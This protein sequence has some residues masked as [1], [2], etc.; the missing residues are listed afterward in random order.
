MENDFNIITEQIGFPCVIK[1]RS[2]GSSI[3]VSIAGTKEELTKALKYATKYE[4]NVLI[5]KLV[6]GREFSVGI[7]KG[8]ALP[9]IEIIP[10]KGFYDYKNK[11]QGGLTK[12]I[13]PAKLSRELTQ[14]VQKRALLVHK[15]LRLGDY[16]RIDF[17]L[18][19]A[20]E[21]ICLEAN[22]ASGNDSHQFN[23]SGSKAKRYHLSKT[24]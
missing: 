7:L 14:K 6:K 17:I 9:V 8:E 3:G 20:D 5:E 16:S 10:L 19:E 12:E 22:T 13:C 23:S 2:N 15:T 4:D 21:F 24:L 1:P 18:N 11:Y